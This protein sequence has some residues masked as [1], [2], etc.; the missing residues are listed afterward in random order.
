MSSTQLANRRPSS[1]VKMTAS[2]LPSDVERLLEETGSTVER[3]VSFDWLSN[4]VPL[5]TKV[6][7]LSRVRYRLIALHRRLGGDYSVLESKTRRPL[8]FDFCV[9]DSILIEIDRRQHFSSHRLITL[10]FYDDLKHDLNIPQ[11]R[12]LCAELGATTDKP[13]RRQGAKDFPFEGGRSA[14]IAY[15]DAARDFLAPAN[16][17][18]LIRLPAANDEL[19]E[20]IDL[21]LRV[22]L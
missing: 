14:Q 16:G 7:S 3:D 12:R 17:F 1:P 15:F 5:D 2:T 10:D 13:R 6:A 9:D 18:R 4:R 20:Q 11:Y 21:V 22:L 19:I 8:R